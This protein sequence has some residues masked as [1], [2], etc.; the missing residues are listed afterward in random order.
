MKHM[1]LTAPLG[2]FGA[3]PLQLLQLKTTCLCDTSSWSAK[4]SEE[5]EK[6]QASEMNV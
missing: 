3:S 6:A 1:V 2:K 4:N 5:Q